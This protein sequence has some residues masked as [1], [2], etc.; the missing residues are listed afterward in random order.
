M[1]QK[2]ET[3]YKYGK[4]QNKNHRRAVTVIGRSKSEW[5]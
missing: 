4:L 1:T 5:A 3:S 2:D